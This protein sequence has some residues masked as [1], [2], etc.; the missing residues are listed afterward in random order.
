MPARAEA[1]S[2]TEIRGRQDAPAAPMADKSIIGTRIATYACMN[3]LRHSASRGFSMVELLIVVAVIGLIVAIAV[4]N[5][6]NAIQRAR[7]TRSVAD[8]SAIAKAVSMYQQD[9]AEYPIQTPLGGADFLKSTLL[10]YMGSFQATDG[11]MRSFQYV[12]DGHEYTILSYGMDGVASLPYTRGSTNLFN[13]DIVITNG[14]FLQWP[15]G[16]QE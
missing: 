16:V 5:L 1:D 7:Q 15:E 3:M 12:S 11:W 9:R 4:P 6:V 14:M 13:A 2:N 8:L 10:T